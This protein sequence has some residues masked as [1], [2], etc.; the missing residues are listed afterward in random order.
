MSEDILAE[1]RQDAKP[2]SK[3]GRFDQISIALHW[4][5]VIL[6]AMQ[7]STAWLA[8]QRSAD[9]AML[10]FVHRSTGTVTWAVVAM[11]LMWRHGSAHLPPFPPRMPKLQ[12]QIAKLSEYA[13]YG[14]LLVQPLTGL[15]N[16][17][18]RGRPFV[19]FAWR[20]PA[21]LT[22]D[23]TISHIFEWLHEFGARALVAL[24]ALHA[25]AA[26]FHGLILRDGVFQ[27]M[28]P[29]TVR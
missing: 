15:G 26:L 6:V 28:L 24:I 2:K 23:R 17:L 29:W 25:A 7:F 3:A 14:L 10:S 20:V 4:L 9:A 21:L 1:D 22:A 11:R 16:T 13:L 12:Q 5:T 8:N 27:R 19:L 18:F